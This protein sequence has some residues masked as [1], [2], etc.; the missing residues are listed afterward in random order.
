MKICPNCNTK[1]SSDA[2]FCIWCGENILNL[3]NISEEIKNSSENISE[4][5]NEIL[6]NFKSLDKNQRII[7]ISALVW[8]VWFFLDF[9]MSYDEYK[10][11][12]FFTSL[13]KTWWN[14]WFLFISSASILALQYLFLI[15]KKDIFSEIKSNLFKIII[16]TFILSLFIWSYFFNWNLHFWDVTLSNY[17]EKWL[18][19][20]LI[21]WS[22]VS[23]FYFS[24][25]EIFNILKR[26]K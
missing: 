8:I 11:I 15:Q 22:F 16:S 19:F 2:K 1:N 23:I 10:N 18:W 9:W 4:K 6:E 13:F 26:F 7:S 24:F 3:E 17:S 20:Y 5:W 12:S 21:F 14:A 25:V